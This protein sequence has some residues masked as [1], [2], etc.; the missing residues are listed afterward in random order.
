M[1]KLC[2]V[3][4]PSTQCLRCLRAHVSYTI[5]PVKHI[6]CLKTHR[7]DHLSLNY[8]SPAAEGLAH[9]LSLSQ[10]RPT[11]VVLPL[12][13][14]PTTAPFFMGTLTCWQ[15]GAAGHPQFHE[16][17][18]PHGTFPERT[19]CGT[20]MCCACRGMTQVHGCRQ[21][22][23]ATLQAAEGKQI[24]SRSISKFGF[25]GSPL[26]IQHHLLHC[27]VPLLAS[28]LLR[29]RTLWPDGPCLWTRRR[30][31]LGY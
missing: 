3:G 27:Q 24:Q 7:T 26:A 25:V 15:R 2:S 19:T 29:S 4:K 1:E 13:G 8:C 16:I 9:P 18:R 17:L 31:L 12:R 23:E 11:R 5:A 30:R 20:A 28:A 6:F 14:I 10:I 21:E 22:S